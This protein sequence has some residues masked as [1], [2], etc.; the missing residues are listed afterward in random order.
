MESNLL[1]KFEK[2]K[3]T[4]DMIP[5]RKDLVEFFQRKGISKYLEIFPKTTNFA[6]FKTMDTDDFEGY[7]ISLQ[8]D[9]N[10][11][12]NA[13]QQACDEEDEEEEREKDVRI[14]YAF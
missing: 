12:L 5:G 7:G 1:Y 3:I 8:D 2:P 4:P 10:V 9:M 6:Y 14:I 11:L 13:V